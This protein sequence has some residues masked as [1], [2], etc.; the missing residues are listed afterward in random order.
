MLDASQQT[1]AIYQLVHGHKALAMSNN[2]KSLLPSGKLSALAQPNTYIQ[3]GSTHEPGLQTKNNIKDSCRQATGTGQTRQRGR[4]QRRWR[5]PCWPR[6]CPCLPRPGRRTFGSTHEGCTSKRRRWWEK[7]SSSA[8]CPSGPGLASHR[9]ESSAG[10]RCSHPCP[11]SCPGPW[12]GTNPAPCPSC[13]Q[14][15]CRWCQPSTCT[16][17]SCSCWCREGSWR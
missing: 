5:Q 12:P 14:R 7:S 4:A 1:S 6:S 10:R 11:S 15:R 2:I 13:R 9:R 8:C 17:S 3:N 16:Y